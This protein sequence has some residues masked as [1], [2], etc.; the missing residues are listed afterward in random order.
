MGLM[1]MYKNP[2]QI[3]LAISLLEV[4]QAFCEAIINNQQANHLPQ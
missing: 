2:T 4:L 1:R 3:A